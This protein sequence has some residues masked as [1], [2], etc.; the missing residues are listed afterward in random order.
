MRSRCERPDGEE[1]ASAVVV[2]LMLMA[3]GGFV[4]L[5]LNMGHALTVRGELQNACDAA[6]LAGAY[7]LN[8]TQQGLASARVRAVDFA[9]RHL[10]DH[11]LPVIIDPASDVTLGTWRSALP[12]ASAFTPVSE[13]APRAARLITAV[14]VRAG[15]ETERG[16]PLDVFFPAF[17]GDATQA[18]VRTEA[19]AA[20]SGPCDACSLPLAFSKCIVEK[21]DGTLDCG[22]TLVFTNNTTNN[23]GFTN[24]TNSSSVGT[25]EIIDILNGGCLTA[26][27]S[28]TIGLGNGNN[29]NKNVVDAFAPYVGKTVAVPIVDTGTCPLKFN[30]VAPVV[31]FASFM[32]EATAGPPNQSITISLQCD[33]TIPSK[34]SGC[35]NFGSFSPIP[36]LIR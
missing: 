26:S 23:V 24:L 22:T 5:V 32:I 3:L 9:Q 16:N 36:S 30:G 31:G 35:A 13:S 2:A 34:T 28:D 29:L 19:V 33:Q 17:S 14:R 27:V 15:R 10:T 7:E 1:G 6:A 18:S 21:S 8:G 4:A 12:R 11:H 25:S 20:R